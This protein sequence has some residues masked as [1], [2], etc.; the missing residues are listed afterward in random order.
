[1][2]ASTAAGCA[3][4]HREHR[5]DPP[6]ALGLDLLRERGRG[7]SPEASASSRTRE[8]QRPILKPRPRPG[9]PFALVWPAAASGNIAPPSLSELPVIALITSTS[10]L[11][12]VP[13]SSS[14]SRYGNPG[15]AARSAA[16]SSR[17]LRR[18]SS[19]AIH[20]RRTAS[21]VNGARAGGEL[22]EAVEV[23]D[24]LAGRCEILGQQYVHD[25]GEQERVASGADEVVLV[26]ELGGAGCGAG[27]RPRCDLA[28]AILDRPQPP[29]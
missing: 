24:E 12:S 11:A 5:P 18:I 28:A 20:R 17:A 1:M 7:S 4:R 8:L 22:L 25:P 16:A 10:Q 6:R 13:N 2:S 9:A 21:G 26:G 14:S 19:S 15:G 3:P 23:G 27:R 29:R